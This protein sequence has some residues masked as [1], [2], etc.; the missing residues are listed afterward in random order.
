MRKVQATATS[1]LC[2]SHYGFNHAQCVFAL[3]VHYLQMSILAENMLFICLSMGLLLAAA[4]SWYHHIN[5]QSFLFQNAHAKVEHTN[6][7]SSGA[8]AFYANLL[9]K[10]ALSKA[11]G[12]SIV[13]LCEPFKGTKSS[14]STVN[15]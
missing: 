13:S 11:L 1:L 5:N 7:P 4:A 14:I 9:L 8:P 3:V 12:G 6:L 10:T 15:S 2:C